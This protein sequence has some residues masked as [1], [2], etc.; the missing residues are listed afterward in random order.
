[1]VQYCTFCCYFSFCGYFVA[2]R[3]GHGSPL[4]VIL[5][6]VSTLVLFVF[7]VAVNDR[8]H[9]LLLDIILFANI[10]VPSSCVLIHWVRI[11]TD[12]VRIAS[13]IVFASNITV[14]GNECYYAADV[15]CVW[16]FQ[17][18]Q[19]SLRWRPK[20]LLQS[21]LW[22]ACGP[23][24]VE[25]VLDC[26]AWPWPTETIFSLRTQ[27]WNNLAFARRKQNHWRRMDGL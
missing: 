24:R 22:F 10:L 8:C 21:C 18:S 3:D 12:P 16:L 19:L 23:Q 5:Q 2:Q 15:Q 4:F 26:R 17:V 20:R 6:F 14:N 1:M 11:Q 7:M 25:G 27:Q 13:N 9:L